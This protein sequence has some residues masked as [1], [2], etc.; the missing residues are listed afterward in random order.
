MQAVQLAIIDSGGANLAS[1]QFALSRLEQ[2]SVIT[3]DRGVIQ[4]AARVILP[5]V[6]A[7]Q[8]AMQTLRQHGLD[9]LVRELT[10]PVLGIC[11]GMQLL[12]DSSEEDRAECLGIIPGIV[13]KLP[14]STELPVPNMGWSPIQVQHDHPLLDGL[15]ADDWFY[16]VHSYALPISANTLASANH[17]GH[18]SAVIAKDNF[19]ATQFH[20]ERS[21]TAGAKILA[22]F[23]RWK[24]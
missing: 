13:R 18:F 10:Q 4:D 15:S 6:G 23:L 1:L 21:S 14:A 24:L 11:L 3:A 7:A 16:F 12:C 8:N 2:E 17:S 22:N 9:S 19:V 5:G 20:P